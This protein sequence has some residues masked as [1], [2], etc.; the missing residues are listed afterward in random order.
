MNSIRIW[1]DLSC[2]YQTTT[3]PDKTFFCLAKTTP[4]YDNIRVNLK[5]TEML[6]RPWVVHLM[7]VEAYHAQKLEIQRCSYCLLHAEVFRSVLV[8]LPR[9]FLLLQ[10]AIFWQI[11]LVFIS[12][13][14]LDFERKILHMCNEYKNCNFARVCIISIHK[15]SFPLHSTDPMWLCSIQ[16]M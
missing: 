11:F 9:C 13:P 3:Q 4:L 15:S 8:S 6:C 10:T 7:V 5:N 1:S 16:F 14:S 12:Y 2:L